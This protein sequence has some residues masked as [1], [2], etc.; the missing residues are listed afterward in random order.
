MSAPAR[1]RCG[2]SRSHGCRLSTFSMSRGGSCL[3]GLTGVERS[4]ALSSLEFPDFVPAWLRLRGARR[5]GVHEPPSGREPKV[6]RDEDPLRA[7][8]APARNGLPAAG[9]A[10]RSPVRNGLPAAGRAKRSPVRNGLPA[11]GR[12]GRSPVRNGLPAAGRAERSPVR[13]GLPAAGRAARSPV[14]NGLPAVGRAARS[15]VRNGLP[16]A[17]RARRS[18]VAAAPRAGRRAAFDGAGLGRRSLMPAHSSTRRA[19]RHRGRDP[20][21]T[22]C[23]LS[24]HRA[25]GRQ[26]AI[27]LPESWRSQATRME[28]RAGARAPGARRRP[29]ATRP[30]CARPAPPSR[31]AGG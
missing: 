26:D 19:T 30:R 28:S 3:M 16:A 31:V 8:R 7:G 15:P 9:R 29:R 23:A 13:N 14:R 4:N 21:D 11:A 5:S 6:W 22:E 1:S 25:S 27:H 12:A 20:A 24:G 17:G 2:V 18:P 10:E